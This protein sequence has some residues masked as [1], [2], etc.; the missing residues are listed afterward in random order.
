M[1]GTPVTQSWMDLINKTASGDSWQTIEAASI[2]QLLPIRAV[3]S[4]SS[5]GHWAERG[6]SNI[7]GRITDLDIDY[8]NERIYALSDHGIIFRSSDL[9]ASAWE[10]LNDQYPLA[11]GVAGQLVILP[12]SSTKMVVGGYLKTTNGWGVRYSHDNGDTWHTPEGIGTYPI[13]GIRRMMESDTGVYL[14]VQEYNSTIPTDYYSVYQSVDSGVSFDLLYRS[15][16]PVG[17]G[18]RHN[19]SDMWVSNDDAHPYL[20]LSLEDSLFQVNKSDGARTYK[21]RISNQ[22]INQGLL[23]GL[24]KNGI[25]ELTAYVAMGDIGKFY[26]WSTSD[27]TWQFQGQ[28]TE[29]WLSLPFGPNSFSCSQISADTLYFGAILTSRSINRGQTWTTIDLDPTESYAL[30]HGDVP[31]TLNIMNPNTGNEET[32]MGTDGGLYKL[33]PEEDH[34]NS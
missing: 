32:Y 18:G 3:T 22:A 6:P 13:M 5:S 17:D 30:Y 26:A 2:R 28:M 24:T 1:D 34:F 9:N 16:V 21:G 31:N 27:Q 15:A 8:F 25:T 23:T 20:Y 10:A 14:F 4:V 19:K 7:P 11:L 33:D 12:D 29:G